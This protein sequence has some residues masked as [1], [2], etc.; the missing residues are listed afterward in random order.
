MSATLTPLVYTQQNVPK[1]EGVSYTKLFASWFPITKEQASLCN[2]LFEEF[3]L[4]VRLIDDVQDETRIR[5]GKPTANVIFGVPLTIN[6]GMLSTTQLM[7]HLLEFNDAQAMKVF[8]EEYKL[9]WEGQGEQLQWT[10]DKR[11]PSLDEVVKMS[12]KKG[13]MVSLFGRF[14][15]ALS[16][17]DDS[18]FIELFKKFNILLQIENDI[19]GTATLRDITEGQYNFVIAY[20]IQEQKKVNNASTSRLEQILLTKTSDQKDLNEARDI[21]VSTGA[22]EFSN[23]Y[24]INIMREIMN[25]TKLIGGN[26]FCEEL[27]T[28]YGT[29]KLQH[30][31]IHWH[32]ED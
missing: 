7:Q 3:Y 5:H 8:L 14:L 1:T 26:T 11:C 22:F 23:N 10:Q 25:S 32:G 30:W 6:D 29:K 20:A 27:M 9:M 16:K 28:V 15:C 2:K 4:T 18:Q 21:L 19:A 12:E 31:G 13:V 24:K 17:K